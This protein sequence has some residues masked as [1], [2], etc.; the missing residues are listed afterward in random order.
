MKAFKFFWLT[1]VLAFLLPGSGCTE[2]ENVENVSG[3]AGTEDAKEANSLIYIG[4]GELETAI[5][6]EMNETHTP[7]T[8]VAVVSGDKIVFA[9][10]F[11]VSNIETGIPVT[12]DTLFRIGSTTK[13]YTAATLVMFDEEGKLEFNEPV[14]SY[15]EGLSS[16]LSQVTAHQLLTHTAGLRDEASSYGR[17]DEAALSEEVRDFDD[18]LFFTEP[19]EIFSYSNPGYALA[20]LVSGRQRRPVFPKLK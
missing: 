18:S 4:T 14:G 19:G 7:G 3:S 5:L 17:H 8:A 10:G 13:M 15:V 1:F 9:R 20:G 6:E 12:P 16:G 11:G 2:I